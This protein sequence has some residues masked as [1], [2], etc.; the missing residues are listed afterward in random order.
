M[1]WV[2]RLAAFLTGAIAGMSIFLILILA[3]SVG[4]AR[5]DPEHP[6]F[7]WALLFGAHGAGLAWP[8]FAFAAASMLGLLALGIV[9]R[10]M[11]TARRGVVVVLGVLALSAGWRFGIRPPGGRTGV[12]QGKFV[13][14]HYEFRPDYLAL[15]QDP[16]RP[17]PRG[18]D[19]VQGA[20]PSDFPVAAAVYV[21]E[22]GWSG[23]HPRNWP[24][25]RSDSHGTLYWQVRLRGTLKGPGQYGR[26]ALMPYRLEVDSVLSV[27]PSR[28]FQD[29]CGVDHSPPEPELRE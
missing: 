24:S 15:C 29:E 7:G 14:G 18:A 23:S 1:R 20:L 22:Q 9:R 27:A 16:G 2:N 8:L 26:P 5:F 17:L 10:E 4:L 25:T 21:P 13:H 19:L 28:I 3:G 6:A 12:F 11:W